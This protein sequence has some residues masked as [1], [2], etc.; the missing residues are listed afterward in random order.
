VDDGKKVA[1]VENYNGG[2]RINFR[3]IE[4]QHDVDCCFS[5]PGKFADMEAVDLRGDLLSLHARGP[6]EPTLIEKALNWLGL[7]RTSPQKESHHWLLIDAKSGQILGQGRDE[8]I[9]ASADGR[10]VVS[11][12]NYQTR[13]KLH[14]L[15]LQSSVTF[16]ATAG[17]AW[18]MLILVGRQWWMRRLKPLVT[19]P[20]EPARAPV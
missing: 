18:S 9:A 10:Y 8:L 19:D 11:G 15:P 13:L 5:I 2:L 12:E 4:A 17:V 14:E 3:D 16:M 7:H 1:W 6:A 20:I